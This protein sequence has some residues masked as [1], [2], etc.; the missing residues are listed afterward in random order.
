MKWTLAVSLLCA[1]SQHRAPKKFGAAIGRAQTSKKTKTVSCTKKVSVHKPKNAI[2]KSGLLKQTSSRV[3][4]DNLAVVQYAACTTSSKQGR[5]SVI[6]KDSAKT[7]GQPSRVRQIPRDS[8]RFYNTCEKKRACANWHP[9]QVTPRWGRCDAPG[10]RRS[11][12]C[13]YILCLVS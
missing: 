5:G 1:R 11:T 13:I 9:F 7:S 3:F 10:P 4:K 2:D 6:R 8:R 12:V